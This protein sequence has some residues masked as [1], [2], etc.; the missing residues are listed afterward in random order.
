MDFLNTSIENPHWNTLT[1]ED[2]AR[3]FHFCPKLTDLTI[4]IDV[5]MHNIG[6]SQI[7]ADLASELKQGFSGLEHVKL[8]DCLKY[9][10]LNSWPI[11]QEILT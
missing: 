2:L 3:V 11:Y 5:S 8:D 6:T 1:L 10:F 7:H 9:L 4:Q